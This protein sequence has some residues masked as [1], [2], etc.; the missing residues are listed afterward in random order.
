[1]ALP[2]S[3][4]IEKHTYTFAFAGTRSEPGFGRLHVVEFGRDLG[5]ASTWLFQ[6]RRDGVYLL[7]PGVAADDVPTV[8][9]WLKIVEFPMRA[10]RMWYA[11]DQHGAAF[12]L[13][14]FERASVPAGSLNRCARIRAHT[15]ESHSLLDFWLAPDQGLIRW[16]RRLSRNRVEVSE[17]MSD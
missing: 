9:G 6:R 17:R 15:G 2:D 16:E 1:V 3:S 12:E 4:I 13:L 14:G 8:P 11:D 5:S 10:E 7:L